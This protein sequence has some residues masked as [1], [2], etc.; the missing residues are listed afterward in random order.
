[1]AR[2]IKSRIICSIPKVNTFG[3]QKCK[4]SET[5]N[6]TLE[7]FEVI[8]LIDYN[9]LTQEEASS[10]ME[11]ARTTVQSIYETAR[12]KISDAL[13][14]GKKIIIEGGNYSLCNAMSMGR[15]CNRKNCQRFSNKFLKE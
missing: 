11:V 5:I 6:M 14:N 3:P 9:N 10:F 2:P 12:K 8:R 1:M 15:K 4:K 13:V 7:E